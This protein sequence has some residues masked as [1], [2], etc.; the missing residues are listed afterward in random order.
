MRSFKKKKYFFLYKHR[1]I[2]SKTF[3][4]GTANFR[5]PFFGTKYVFNGVMKNKIFLADVSKNLFSI[6]SFEIQWL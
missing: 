2:T 1:N 4:N 6:H 5:G 3:N